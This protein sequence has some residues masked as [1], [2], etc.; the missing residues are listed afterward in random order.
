MASARAKAQQAL[1]RTKQN[2]EVVTFKKLVHS[3]LKAIGAALPKHMD[4][5]R[6]MRVI[7]TAAEKN[8]RLFECTAMS[9][10]KCIV[11][12]SQM[13]LE[14]DGIRG[15]AYLIPYNNRKENRYE[16]QLQLGYKGMI[17]L[18]LR[19]GK[20]ASI[21][22]ELVYEGEHFVWEEGTAARLE[23]R[24]ALDLAEDAKVR[25]AYAVAQLADGGSV[26]VVLRMKDIAKR[27]AS[28]KAQRID[29]PWNTHWEA[30]ARKTA[31]RAL[32]SVLPQSPELQQAAVV[33][34]ARDERPD[35][36]EASFDLLGGGAENAP[37]GADPET[38]EVVSDEEAYVNQ[39]PPERVPGQEG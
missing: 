21:H 25:C 9:L 22:A 11:E 26:H 1:A 39:G 30:M 19:S 5:M 37:G 38:G 33:D 7:V 8:P 36:I 15:H 14:P 18:A 4:P 27:R 16:C 10:Q 20:V 2:E 3:Q 29:S 12:V 35:A 17:E 28:S 13:G 24:P 6:M 31:I 32:A 23:H 34:E